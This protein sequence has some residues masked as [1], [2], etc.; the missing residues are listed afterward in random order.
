MAA[1]HVYRTAHMILPMDYVE[2]GRYLENPNP[3]KK[4][5]A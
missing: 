2:S 3:Q 1:Y 4:K 5:S